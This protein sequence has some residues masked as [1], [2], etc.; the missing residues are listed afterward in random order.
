MHYP[1][2]LACNK[3]KYKSALSA[4]AATKRDYVE[5]T[6][7]DVEKHMVDNYV[8]VLNRLWMLT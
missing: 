3:N 4:A 8:L 5:V 2:Y 7:D 1:S 6:P